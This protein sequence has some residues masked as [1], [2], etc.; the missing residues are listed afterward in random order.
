MD[1][2]DPVFLT[3]T[4]NT[5]TTPGEIIPN[6]IFLGGFRIIPKELFAQN[7]I[8]PSLFPDLRW[9]QIKCICLTG[10]Y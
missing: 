4:M 9:V 7:S 10:V 5:F 3:Q 2:Y 8:L 6:S 1:Y